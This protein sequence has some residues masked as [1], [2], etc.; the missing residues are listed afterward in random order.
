MYTAKGSA[1]SQVMG[2]PHEAL[3]DFSGSDSGTMK[4]MKTRLKMVIMVA[5]R[6]TC[7]CPWVWSSIHVPRAGLITRL[8]AKVAD[9]YGFGRK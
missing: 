9:T 1:C 7:A 8:A 5:R 4:T 6:I 3:R 2:A